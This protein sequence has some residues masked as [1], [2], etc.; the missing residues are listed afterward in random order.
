M[1]EPRQTATEPVTEFTAASLEERMSGIINRLS[2]A[3]ESAQNLLNSI[4]GP[5]PS[6]AEVEGKQLET[7]TGFLP[8]CQS[9]T[10]VIDKEISMLSDAL[11]QCHFLMSTNYTKAKSV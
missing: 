7:P 9:R 6:G 4:S 10:D 11:N 3:R 8:G 2:E 5:I 1:N